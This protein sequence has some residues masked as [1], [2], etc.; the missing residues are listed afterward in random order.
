[1]K[2]N[3][4]D[5]LKWWLKQALWFVPAA[6]CLN[7]IYAI[8]SN[9]T[10]GT[11]GD[12]FGAA[13]ALFSGT[14]LLM[15]VLAVI[16]QRD[17]LEVVKEERDATREILDSQTELNQQQKSALNAQMLDQNFFALVNIM[18]EQHSIL[19][20]YVDSKGTVEDPS[21]TWWQ[22][23]CYRS[24]TLIQQFSANPRDEREFEQIL[25]V[26][27]QPVTLF[28]ETYIAAHLLLEDHFREQGLIPIRYTA[29]LN[30]F[31]SEAV[32]ACALAYLLS[33][34]FDRPVEWS[35]LAFDQLNLHHNLPEGLEEAHEYFQIARQLQRENSRSS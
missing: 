31:R 28:L 27:K 33:T 16:L 19:S 8:S 29:I 1:M 14:A 32:A 34:S 4:T 21:A 2:K 9:Q 20:V 10:G 15:L 26:T 7:F 30:S 12:T 24:T 35:R 18:Q 11:F 17:E 6:Y 22:V 23:C 13:N 5:L 25:G 3:K